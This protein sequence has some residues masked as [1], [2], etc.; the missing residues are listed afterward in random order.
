MLN[1]H[2]LIGNFTISTAYYYACF[3][4]HV[5]TEHQKIQALKVVA[6]DMLTNLDESI[7][8]N[9]IYA[10]QPALPIEAAVKENESTL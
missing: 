9:L 8:L 2:T 1:K 5:Y 4:S 6:K 3:Y 10:S 7:H